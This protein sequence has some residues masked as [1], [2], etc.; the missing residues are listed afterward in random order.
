VEKGDEKAIKALKELGAVVVPVAQGSN[1]LMANFVTVPD[2]NDEQVKLLQ[3][4]QKQLVWLKLSDTKISDKALALVGEWTNLTLLYLNNTS[5]TD[6]G[7]ISL[8]RLTNLQLFSA[9]NTAITAAGLQ[10]LASLQ[11]LQS[12]YVYH[13]G[14]KE[15]D[16]VLLRKSFP[17][18]AIDIGGY[19]IPFL[20]S[21]TVRLKPPKA[22]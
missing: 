8:K 7:L 22:N 17:K 2:M 13:T 16:T 20:A 10:Q 9:V 6:K 14:I 15:S 21:D 1:Y 18:T 3:P 19:S 12:I 5:I 4:L 11:K